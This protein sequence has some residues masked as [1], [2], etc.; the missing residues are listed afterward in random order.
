LIPYFTPC[1]YV[2]SLARDRKAHTTYSPT[3]SQKRDIYADLSETIQDQKLRTALQDYENE[4]WRIVANKVGTGFTPA[5][6][7][8]RAAQLMMGEGSSG[9]SNSNDNDNSNEDV[10]VNVNL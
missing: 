3:I 9:N 6:C 10:N 5:A 2:N 8:E 7:R 1:R 4:K